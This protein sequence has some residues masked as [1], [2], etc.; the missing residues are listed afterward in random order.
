MYRTLV[1]IVAIT[2]IGTA[3]AD[4]AKRHKRQLR[5]VHA[6]PVAS[7]QIYP[8][9]P[10]WGAPGQCWSDEGYGRFSSCDNGRGR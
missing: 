7:Q 1:A 3:A 2:L 9:R 10:I 4:A 8:N 6:A 5:A